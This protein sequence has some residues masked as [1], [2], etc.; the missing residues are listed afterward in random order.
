MI[1][2][3]INL[4]NKALLPPKLLCSFTHLIQVVIIITVLAALS[5]GVSKWMIVS[6]SNVISKQNTQLA[7]LT[8]EQQNLARKLEANKADSRLLAQVDLAS[9]RLKLKQLL[10]NEL[11]RRNTINSEGFSPLLTDLASAPMKNLWL[12]KIKVEDQVFSFEGFAL[13]AQAVPSWI[14]SLKTT[15]T[16]KG[17]SF[18]TMTMSRG[19]KKPLAFVLTSEPSADDT[20]LGEQ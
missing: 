3:R 10:L 7:T 1:K 4:F 9:S 18:A 8:A 19:D 5:L 11:E 12:N 15:Q 13:N 16:L 14:G 6:Q 2:K 20:S 17:M